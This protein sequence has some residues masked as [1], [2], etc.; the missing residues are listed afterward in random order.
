MGTLPKAAFSAVP[1]EPDAHPSAPSEVAG[2]AAGYEIVSGFG[3]DADGV[4][5]M[6]EVESA[7]AGMTVELARSGLSDV[8]EW[9]A[10]NGLE[11][12]PGQPQ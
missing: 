9:V 12:G 10:G 1:G 11:A 2:P 4:G 6:L 7:D 3:L 8:V 5:T